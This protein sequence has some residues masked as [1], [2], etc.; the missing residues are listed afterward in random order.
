MEIMKEEIRDTRRA[1]VEDQKDSSSDAEIL[2]DEHRFIFRLLSLPLD[3][4]SR[5]TVKRWQ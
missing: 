5:T 3:V 4:T 1:M 2:H